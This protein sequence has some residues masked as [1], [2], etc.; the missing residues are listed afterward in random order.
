M[1]PLQ[2]LEVF[3]SNLNLALCFS[4]RKQPAAFFSGTTIQP[5]GLLFNQRQWLLLTTFSVCW[6]KTKSS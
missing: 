4:R 5:G 3:Q 1:A 2:M 6:K